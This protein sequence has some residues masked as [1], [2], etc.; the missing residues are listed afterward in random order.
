[1]YLTDT[2]THLHFEQYAADLGDVLRRAQDQGV[3]K[4]LS[5]GTDY[6]SSLQT[7]QISD[8]YDI[9]YAAT[10]IH[11]T[12]V[13]KGTTK[14]IERVRELARGQNKIVAIGEIG[15]DLYWKEVPLEKQ[16]PVFEKMLNIAVD[17]DLPVV[18]HVREAHR[19]MREFFEKRQ[20]QSLKGVMHSFSGTAEDARFYLERGLHISFTGVVTFKNFKGI[21]VVRSVPLDRILLETDSPF[22]TPVPNRGKRN[23]P[24]FVEFVAKRLAEIYELP[25]QEIAHTTFQNANRLFRWNI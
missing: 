1:M 19:E 6:A 20:I 21:E 7:L 24:A 5:L 9:V 18:I 23:E 22:L 13:F 15:F 14:D 12:D 11:P 2:H 16:I 17:L 25:L 4:I 3:V 10:G 8:Q